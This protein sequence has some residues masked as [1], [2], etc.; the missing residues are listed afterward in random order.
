MSDLPKSA[1]GEESFAWLQQRLDEFEASSAFMAS[2]AWQGRH[3]AGRSEK[4]IRGNALVDMIAIAENFSVL[5]L[6]GID[7]TLTEDQVSNWVK[8][9]AEWKSRGVDFDSDLGG[10]WPAMSGFIEARNA[11]QHGLG[12]ITD[13]QLGKKRRIDVLR[14]LGAC[15]VLVDGG[16]L[17]LFDSDVRHCAEL[18]ATFILE[19]DNRAP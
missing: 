13:M 8:R 18:C 10:V 5:R 19:L 12:E 6:R 2:R 11:V 7:D 14:G 3:P 15:G 1:A 4:N 17:R 16:E 9:K